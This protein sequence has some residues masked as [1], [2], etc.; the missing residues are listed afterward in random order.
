M[1]KS[2]EP[3]KVSL[4]SSA[5]IDAAE[6]REHIYENDNGPRRYGRYSGDSA[7]FA[8][9]VRVKISQGRG[10]HPATDDWSDSA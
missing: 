4:N 6:L 8:Q 9:W 7:H 2:A 5:F 1:F 10:A 3:A